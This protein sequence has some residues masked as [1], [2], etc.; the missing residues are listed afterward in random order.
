MVGTAWCEDPLH[1]AGIALVKRLL[2][3]LQLQAS[4][5]IPEPGNP[6]YTERSEGP[7][8]VVATALQYAQTALLYQVQ[9]ASTE[10]PLARGRHAALRCGRGGMTAR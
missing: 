7:D 2:R 1:R 9:A 6:L 4:G 3:E 10:S 8:R 5:R